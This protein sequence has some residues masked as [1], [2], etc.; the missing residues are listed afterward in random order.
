LVLD[1]V[2]SERLL[3]GRLTVR[4]SN[5]PG[6][7]TLGRQPLGRRTLRLPVLRGRDV[8]LRRRDIRLRRFRVCLR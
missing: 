3:L 1:R 5:R 7:R 4:W 6:L 2:P 8:E